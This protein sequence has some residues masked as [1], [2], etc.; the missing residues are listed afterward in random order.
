MLSKNMSP[1]DISEISGIPLEYVIGMS[2]GTK[3]C[4][5]LSSKP[6]I[7][8]TSPEFETPVPGSY[9]NLLT[10]KVNLYTC[11]NPPWDATS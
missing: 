3:K 2:S 4:L 10:I 8:H 11:I 7:W 6:P 1:E 5:E 9:P